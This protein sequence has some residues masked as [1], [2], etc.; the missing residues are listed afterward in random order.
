MLTWWTPV[1]ASDKGQQYQFYG[2]NKALFGHTEQEIM[3][4][5]PADTGKTLAALT[6]LNQLAWKYPNS[7]WSISSIMPRHMVL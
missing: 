5:G 3:L 1:S 4:A 2:D 7:Q 6:Y